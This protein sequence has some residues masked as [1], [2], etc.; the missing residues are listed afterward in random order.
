MAWAPFW[1]TLTSA[2]PLVESRF[3]DNPAVS[4]LNES[5]SE[6]DSDILYGRS[7]DEKI[8]YSVN[9]M[10]NLDADSDWVF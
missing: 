7:K 2:V 9:F 3:P 1:V 10:G 5:D 6:S 8:D 4:M